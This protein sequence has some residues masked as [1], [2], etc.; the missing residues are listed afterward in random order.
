MPSPNRATRRAT[1]RPTVPMVRLHDLT[2][3]EA[4]LTAEAFDAYRRL[5][6]DEV[7]EGERT[8]LQRWAYRRAGQIGEMLQASVDGRP[9]YDEHGE[10][11]APA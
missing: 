5:M 7:P 3:P 2:M 11:V 9:T 8:D 6:D 1:K 10:R 4:E